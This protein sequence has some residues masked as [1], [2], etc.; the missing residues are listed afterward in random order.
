MALAL[1]Q[2]IL[3]VNPLSENGIIMFAS[4]LSPVVCAL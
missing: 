1:F 4:V 3:M 2:E